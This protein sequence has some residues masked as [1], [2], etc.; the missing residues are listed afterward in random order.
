[1]IKILSQRLV[2]N[3]RNW[4]NSQYLRT[5]E[6]NWHW[7]RELRRLTIHIAISTQ[8]RDSWV[9][10]SFH[11]EIW[12]MNQYE[13]HLTGNSIS[14]FEPFFYHYSN[15]ESWFMFWVTI[16]TKYFE[17]TVFCHSSM[18]WRSTKCYWH[19]AA[20]TSNA[21]WDR[22]PVG[23][24]E[25]GFERLSTFYSSSI[26]KALGRIRNNTNIY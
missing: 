20:L 8:N 23:W 19:L 13:N 9:A 10:D 16:H 7:Q 1:M 22:S 21:Y 25:T 5:L 26:L 14:R 15:F 17:L 18:S 4:E 3:P 12:F 6:M 24:S 11:L 2:G